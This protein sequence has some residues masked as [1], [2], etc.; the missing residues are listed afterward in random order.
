[1]EVRMLQSHETLWAVQ[2]MQD[3]YNQC[4]RP[5]VNGEEEVAKFFQ[6]VNPENFQNEI[7][8]GRLTLWG[9]FD[10]GWMCGV[11][12]LQGDGHVSVLYVRPEYQGMKVDAALSKRMKRYAENVLGIGGV[13]YPVKKVS[14]KVVLGITAG[15]FLFMTVLFAGTTVYHMATDGLISDE[16][17]YERIKEKE[18][19]RE[20]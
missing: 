14:N 7:N 19:E 20:E 17:Y 10:R 4:V 11:S 8:Q 16:V 5:T 18:T 13:R 6:Y 15:V 1:M 9:A 12:A 2:M 3:I